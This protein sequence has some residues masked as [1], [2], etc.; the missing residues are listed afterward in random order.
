[1][2][3]DDLVIAHGDDLAAADGAVGADARHF[4]RVGDLER[5]RFGLG[6]SQIEAESEQ[7]AESKAARRAAKKVA[8]M[9]MAN[10]HERPS[11]KVGILPRWPLSS[12][13]RI[14]RSLRSRIMSKRCATTTEQSQ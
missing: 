2:D 4:F 11:D 10:G 6:R 1:L 9:Q 7:T 5:A 3:V 13:H 14:Q 8:A 12:H